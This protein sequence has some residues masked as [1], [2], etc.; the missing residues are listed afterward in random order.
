MSHKQAIEALDR[1]LKDIRDNNNLMGGL[2][3]LLAGDFRQTLPFVQR[4]TAADELNACIK[5]F[6]LWNQVNKLKLQTNLR[7]ALH[8]DNSARTFADKLLKIGEDK[9][10]SDNDG[11]ISLTRDFCV[12]VD[13]L[14]DLISK[15]YPD[16]HNNYLDENWLGDRAILA[17]T[18][19]V[20]S[21][22][23]EEV[24]EKIPGASDI[25]KSIDLVINDDESTACPQD[26]L[27]A[28]EA[29]GVPLHELKL[30]IGVPAILM[31]NL[32]PPKLCND[33]RLRITKVQQYTI[34]AVIITGCSKG[35][36]IIL[37]RIPIVPTDLP[38]EFKRL[39]FPIK[40]PSIFDHNK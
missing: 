20:V 11:L 6:I 19:D 2:V 16:I 32:D 25:Y 35:E 24:M 37:P 18:N 36:E 27:N 13:S 12:P 21:N 22:I 34:T 31:R 40:F 30:K 5:S 17:P 14:Q 15:V 4:G 33:T 39:Q 9:L 7:V 10:E 26:F 28:I 8:N 23:N 29:S 38:F 1:S 3:V